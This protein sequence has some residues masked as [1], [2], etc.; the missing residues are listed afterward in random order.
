MT[1]RKFD[2]AA[3]GGLSRRSLLQSAD[4]ALSFPMI[5]TSSKAAT[6]DRVAG[7]GEVVAYGYGGSWTAAVRQN[8]HEPFTKA[9][10]INVVDVAADYAGPQ[11]KAMF[12]AG[13]I[14]WDLVIFCMAQN[15]PI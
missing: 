8:I 6:Q 15:M 10:G 3:F 9:T 7:T 2:S 4:A 12:S 11:S 1:D 5:A 14:D 13:R